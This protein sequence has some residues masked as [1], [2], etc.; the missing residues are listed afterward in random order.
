MN[1]GEIYGNTATLYNNSLNSYGGGVYVDGS[2][3]KTGGTIYGYTEGNSNSNVVK[4]RTEV[5]QQQKGHAIYTYHDNSVY[6]M[7]KDS[8][9]GTTD[10][11][12]FN[13]NVNPPAWSGE[14]DF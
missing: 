6:I 4:D 7:G 5:V 8:T 10:N 3:N 13:G 14:W 11:L 2:F 1:G 12:S 9:S